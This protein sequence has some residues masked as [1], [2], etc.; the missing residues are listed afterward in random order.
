MTDPI[1]NF[2][3]YGF[4]MCS[5]ITG[6]NQSLYEA[7]GLKHQVLGHLQSHRVSG[8]VPRQVPHGRHL[9]VE[10]G[11]EDD[12]V[13]LAT[14]EEAAAESARLVRERSLYA[15]S[16]NGFLTGTDTMR[17]LGGPRESW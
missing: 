9:D 1:R 4:T 10:P 16:P 17:N 13:T 11:D 8:R 15:T 2:S 12:G 6:I 3:D 14:V 5:T 7:I